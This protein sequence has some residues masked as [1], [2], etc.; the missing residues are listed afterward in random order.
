MTTEVGLPGPRAASEAAP[1]PGGPSPALLIGEVRTAMLQHSAALTAELATDLLRFAPGDRVRASTRPIGHVLSA[2]AVDGVH[3]LL[4]TASGT[5]TDAVGTVLARASITGGRVLQASART[6]VTA[7]EWSFRPP[8]SHFLAT[9]GVVHAR[10]RADLADL[11][12]GHLRE[13]GEGRRS[14]LDLDLGALAARFVDRVQGSPFLDRRPG[15]RARRTR[16][17]FAAR[18]GAGAESKSVA[19][20]VEFVIHDDVLRTISLTVPGGDPVAIVRLCEDLALHDWLLTTVSRVVDG[21]RGGGV[22]GEELAARFRPVVTHLLPLWMPAAF[23]SDELA[24]VWASLEARPGFSRHWQSLVD[25]I[26]D[27]LSLAMITLLSRGMDGPP[28]TP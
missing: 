11:T 12:G 20:S 26:R 9:P 3:C 6:L 28:E 10:G 13:N 4:P 8:W 24:A 23:V 22:P 14:D 2:D 5:R 17:R 21:G 25:Q 7:R 27:H 19:H 18:L 15:L 1:A 16:L